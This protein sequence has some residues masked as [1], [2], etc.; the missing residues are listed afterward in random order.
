MYALYL[1]GENQ[2]K[3][4]TFEKSGD[5][6]V[7]VQF[8]CLCHLDALSKTFLWVHTEVILPLQKNSGRKGRKKLKDVRDL[9]GF[10]EKSVSKQISLLYKMAEVETVEEQ[11]TSLCSQRAPE[12]RKIKNNYFLFIGESIQ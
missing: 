7:N 10:F 5:Y 12:V 8:I 3:Y 2:K 1:F 9:D 6:A 11:V 4:L